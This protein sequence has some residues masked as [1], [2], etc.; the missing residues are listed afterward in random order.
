MLLD[1]GNERFNYQ[2]QRNVE[3]VIGNAEYV[4]GTLEQF[5]R[6]TEYVLGKME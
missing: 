4:A 5:I 2:P 3:Q 1:S 6:S